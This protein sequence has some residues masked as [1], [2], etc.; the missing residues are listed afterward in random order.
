MKVMR[1]VSIIS[2][3][4]FFLLFVLFYCN[5][6]VAQYYGHEW[7]DFS[8]DYYKVQDA[9]TGFFK[10]SY[11]ELELAGFPVTQNPKEY[12]LF[13]RGKEV[14]IRVIG[15]ADGS[16]DNG[17][18]I[19]YYG[20]QM[21][22][23]SDAQLYEGTDAQTN[24]YIN[25]FSDTSAYFLTH[26]V[27]NPKRIS[28]NI[29]ETSVSRDYLEKVS[30]HTFLENYSMGD[31]PVNYVF[32]SDF[33]TG[34]GWMQSAKKIGNTPNFGIPD[35][36][37]FKNVSGYQ[38]KLEVRLCGRNK[39]T[40]K[41]SIAIGEANTLTYDF[42][43]F[44]RYNH[45]TQNF[46]WNY[47]QVV[48]GSLTTS[49]TINGSGGNTDV[50]SVVYTRYYF[51]ISADVNNT[52]PFYFNSF[53]SIESTVN[54]DF[55][56]TPIRSLVFDV[57]D[58]FNVVEL[59]HSGDNYTLNNLDQGDKDYVLLTE[60][61]YLSPSKIEPALFKND[62]G[63]N[64]PD[65]L[66]IYHEKFKEQAEN[67]KTY[68][69][70][71]AGGGYRVE[72]AD[73]ARLFDQYSF[74]ERSPVSIRNYCHYML[75][76]YDPSY[77][78]LLGNGSV[79]SLDNGGADYYRKTPFN[80]TSY[81]NQDFVMTMGNPGS[82]IMFSNKIDGTSLKPDLATGRV[83]CYTA[84]EAQTYLDKVIEHE[85]V[86]F[87]DLW[88]KNLLHLSGGTTESESNMFLNIV[89]GFEEKAV[90]VHYGAEVET[91]SKKTDD[92]VEFINVSEPVNAGVG[93]ITFI[94]HS[95]PNYTELDIGLASNDLNGYNN[96][97]KYTLLWI[98]GC[99]A[100]DV[101]NNYFRVRTRDWMFTKD[102][103]SIGAFGHGSYGLTFTLAN[104]TNI[105]YKYAFQ[106]SSYTYK[107]LGQVQQKVIE[108]FSENREASIYYSSHAV[109][110]N[111]LGDPAIHY[112]RPKVADYAITNKSLAIEPFEGKGTIT[113]VSDSFQLVI[114]IENY[115]LA[116]DDSLTVCIEREYAN[117]LIEY[118]TRTFPIYHQEQIYYTVVND[119]KESGGVNRFTVTL[120]CLSEYEELSKENNS[121]FIEYL[122][123]FNGV[124]L[125]YPKEFAII[126]E[127]SVDLVFQSNDLLVDTEFYYELEIDTS[128]GFSSPVFRT[129]VQGDILGTIK[130]Y[131]LP[132]TKD[133]T[134]YYWRVRF[135]ETETG[136]DPEW[137]MSSF[138]YL[139]QE[140]GWGQ[141]ELDQFYDNSLTHIYRDLSLGVWKFDTTG[142]HVDATTIGNG[143]SGYNT[144]SY[145]N[146][147][148]QSIV[149]SGGRA[150]CTKNGM[151]I[152]VFDSETALPYNTQ[153]GQGG[154]CGRLPRELAKS[155]SSLNK[156]STQAAVVSFLNTINKND[157]ILVV[158]CGNHY[159]STWGDEMKD[160][161]RQFGANLVDDI[162]S[163]SH[164]YIFLGQDGETE[165]L[166]EKYGATTSDTVILDY[167]LVGRLTK[168]I[169]KSPV[170]GPTTDWGEYEHDFTRDGSDSIAV[171]IYGINKDG[172]RE[173]VPLHT[174]ENQP[175]IRLDLKNDVQI[176]PD[177]Y[178]SLQIEALI[179]DT[180]DNTAAQ[181]NHWMVTF[182]EIPEAVINTSII[183]VESYYLDELEHGA[184]LVI[185]YHFQNISPVDFIDSV[186]V[187]LTIK[188]M[189]K[190]SMII[191]YLPPLISGDTLS[192]TI[193]I[194]TYELIG[195]NTIQVYFNPFDQ[196]ERVYE[197]NLL[198]V[199]FQVVADVGSPV[200]D[201]L[202]DDIHIIDGDL[203]SPNPIISIYY[204][205]N[206]KLLNKED[207]VGLFLYLKSPCDS[208]FCNY[209]RIYFSD[210]A[211]V[212]WSN[213]TIDTPFF[214]EY[215]PKDLL[216]GI[217]QLKVQGQDEAA[218]VSGQI[219]YGISFEVINERSITNFHPFPNPFTTT[220][221]F[222]FTITGDA[223]PE[224]ISI[225]IYSSEGELVRVISKDEL[226]YIH[227]G[228]NKTEYA[229][230]GKDTNGVELSNGMYIYHVLIENGAVDIKYIDSG[231]DKYKQG[232][233]KII[234]M[235]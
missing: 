169:I 43:D 207:T 50:I 97:G 158:T 9:R 206:N 208:A 69:S 95:A 162:P 74:G 217:H 59:F 203:V 223:I 44:E 165:A 192:Y 151:W 213:Q 125:L 51:A 180:L 108:E 126:G 61:D 60:D 115:G 3:R 140:T 216:N 119:I 68:R 40:H 139:S 36:M 100:T 198:M 42:D 143:V 47:D 77:L 117:E 102:R 199:P 141:M 54:V 150:Y 186:K 7:I 90:G 55:T 16:F 189:L 131:N 161:L 231:N 190:D 155:F 227:A 93:M 114:N 185:T 149:I 232:I 48:D 98:N 57:S 222:A 129:E 70:S 178:P 105:F 215:K 153:P 10:I 71:V 145:V 66:I 135:S 124:T 52:T 234:I 2:I 37:N 174:I 88:R 156:E 197:N 91:Q 73:Q 176:D 177:L 1:K 193:S 230:D 19:I 219:A 196:L 184:P 136:Q 15:E 63:L 138:T 72:I 168:G 224:N 65:Y 164:P 67:F 113:A 148:E 84:E 30:E 28:R 45:I 12:Q 56:N 8:R 187:E 121:A 147:D 18:Y 31:E 204:H 53:T 166:S 104:Y 92:A 132:I 146:V 62:E 220:C 235:K 137:V 23:A 118:E 209:E 214:I 202:F 94:G 106:D 167:D 33:D 81:P 22:G 157:M 226:G 24:P 35:L 49:G 171:F 99:Q 191:D 110:F 130:D 4:Q 41:V 221:R 26:S 133:S 103:G 86:E 188:G 112:F 75:A 173:N 163:D 32:K 76:N 85:A 38:P 11:E 122:I 46:N 17:D 96:K 200:T 194:P 210:T 229:W 175:K 211:I 172:E 116:F 79:V 201:V 218:N 128:I 111:Y 82:D 160:K 109:Q 64:A 212:S 181:L 120:D 6:V 154:K 127:E 87:D 5:V 159:A 83:P 152:I 142:S 13:R 29:N 225:V 195:E 183:G 34:E 101:Y 14:A 58:G 205:D 27:D 89:H 80:H 20:Q 233:G 107:S 21:D 182:A 123:P 134:V 179:Y 78:L 39:F 228:H 25:L 144:G 170:I